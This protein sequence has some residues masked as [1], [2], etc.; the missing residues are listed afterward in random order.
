MTEKKILAA[1]VAAVNLPGDAN[2][3]TPRAIS[4]KPRIKLPQSLLRPRMEPAGNPPKT[5]SS[6][7]VNIKEPARMVSVDRSNW[8]VRN[9]QLSATR[10][11]N[12]VSTPNVTIKGFSF[13]S[14]RALIR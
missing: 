7:S 6:P 8:L 11:P 1:I 4:S 9:G 5:W 12:M 13:R 14:S 10:P 3:A 2:A